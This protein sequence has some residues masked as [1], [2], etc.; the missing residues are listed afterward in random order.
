MARDVRSF[1]KFCLFIVLEQARNQ[2][3]QGCRCTPLSSEK[4]VQ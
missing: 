4:G 1:F 2:G 3:V